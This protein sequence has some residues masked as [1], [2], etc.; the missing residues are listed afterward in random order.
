MGQNKTQLSFKIT[1]LSQYGIYEAAGE[2]IDRP[3]VHIGLGTDPSKSCIGNLWRTRSR[4]HVGRLKQ[5]KRPRL[6]KPPP[7]WHTTGRFTKGAVRRRS[8]RAWRRLLQLC[9]KIPRG[10]LWRASEVYLWIC[11]SEVRLWDRNLSCRTKY[12]VSG[13]QDAG[14][15]CSGCYWDCKRNL[16]EKVFMLHQA[17]REAWWEHR[18]SLLTHLGTEHRNPEGKT[19]RYWRL[20]SIY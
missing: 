18:K 7:R 9:Q 20:K 19:Q 3:P 12:G 15:R 10:R 14:G 8:H 2:E 1:Y 4:W 17:Q 16:E 13:T 5:H 11:G 6:G